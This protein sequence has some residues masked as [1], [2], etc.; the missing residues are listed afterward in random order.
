[1]IGAFDDVV[2]HFKT[3]IVARTQLGDERILQ[4]Y[5]VIFATVGGRF[6]RASRKIDFGF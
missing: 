6:H 4:A 5:H 1:M 2:F 3:Q